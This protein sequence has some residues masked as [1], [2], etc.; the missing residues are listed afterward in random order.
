MTAW[1]S[2]H[3]R[4]MR[5]VSRE[6]GGRLAMCKTRIG[7]GRTSIVHLRPGLNFGSPTNRPGAAVWQV[8]HENGLPSY[9]ML[10]VFF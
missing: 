10:L 1:Y 5:V 6:S 7:Q 4:I 8:L 3:S 2:M 9:P